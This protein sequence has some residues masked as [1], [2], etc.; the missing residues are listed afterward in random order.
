MNTHGTLS[1]SIM[2]GKGGVG[3]TNI[4][5]NLGLALNSLD[6]SAILMDC[7][8]GLAN[9]DVLLGANP[10]GTLQDI[11]LHGAKVSDVVYPVA[12]GFDILPAASGVPELVDMDSDT[13]NMLFSRLMPVL[14][15]YD[16]ALLDI[17]AGITPTVQ[18]FARM[19]KVKIMVLTPEPTSLTDS[20]ALIKVLATQHGV[21]DFWVV[22]NQAENRK[23]EE[24][25]FGRLK[26]ACEHFL[27]IQPMFLGG[28]RHD[29]HVV[30]AVRKQ[31]PFYK[32][33]PGCQ[34]ATDINAIARKLQQLRR[35]L[36]ASL[37][38][39]AVLVS[40]DA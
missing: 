22:V 38:Q 28:V 9:L 10:T 29:K 21:K 8:L 24:M 19:A 31:V 27:G 18:A 5:L 35:S 17:G 34:A 2:S 40:L 13:R 36:H 33:F 7:D 26:A 3:K 16:Y 6:S 32:L 15:S 1:I 14:G 37:V 23:E 39:K 30:E 12:Q 25:T 11:L 4:A 20:Y